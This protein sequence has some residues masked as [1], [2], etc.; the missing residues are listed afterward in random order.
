MVP[1]LVSL[2]ATARHCSRQAQGW[3]HLHIREIVD[4]RLRALQ[5]FARAVAETGHDCRRAAVLPVTCLLTSGEA[6]F[7]QE[8]LAW[9]MAQVRAWRACSRA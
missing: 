3:E 9:H 5:N 6:A 8:W 1:A 7:L 2:C 4:A